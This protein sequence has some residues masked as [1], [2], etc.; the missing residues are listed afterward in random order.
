MLVYVPLALVVINSFNVDRTFTW[1]PPSLTTKW[2]D[3]AWHSKGARSALWTSV[4]VALAAT[5]IALVL[6]WPGWPCD[7]PGSSGATWSPW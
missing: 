5:A 3:A 2:W 7:R 4:E 1:P 6:G